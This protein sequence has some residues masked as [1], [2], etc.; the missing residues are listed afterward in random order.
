MAEKPEKSQ[1]KPP[2]RCLPASR[3]TGFYALNTKTSNIDYITDAN[4]VNRVLSPFLPR[5][6]GFE[7]EP[8]IL[9]G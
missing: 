4:I 9:G 1:K 6:I 3:G 7:K 8:A 5:G 2:L